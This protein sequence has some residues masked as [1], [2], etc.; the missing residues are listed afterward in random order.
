MNITE[1][2]DK[3]GMEVAGRGVLHLSVL[4][5][6]MRRE[7]YEFQVGRPQ[8]IIKNEGGK[9]LANR[10]GGCRRPSDTLA[11]SSRSA[12]QR[13]DD[14]HGAAPTSTCTEFEDSVA[15]RDGSAHAHP[16]RHSRRGDALPPL[17]RVRSLQR[18]RRAAKRLDDRDGHREVRGVRA[19]LTAAAG[20]DVHRTGVSATRA[21][22]WARTP[23][24][25]TLSST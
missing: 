5:E 17:Q 4:M 1:T 3:S 24:Q 19:R 22:S 25:A 7:G 15:R 14:R 8:V 6:T 23:R 12:A 11:K 2:E 10:A 13:R 18:A 9:K 16:E 21:W 20:Q